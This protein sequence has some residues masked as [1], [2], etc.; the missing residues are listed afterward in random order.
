MEKLGFFNGWASKKVW[1][2]TDKEDK[3]RVYAGIF[4]LKYRR[5]MNILYSNDLN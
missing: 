1:G 3:A 5:S 4:G 2:E